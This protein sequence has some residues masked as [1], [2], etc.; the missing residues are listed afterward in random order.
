MKRNLLL[1]AGIFVYA[2][3]FAQGEIDAFR[4]SGTDLSGTARGQAM[5]GAFGA[6]GGDIT[7]ISINPA[8]I[9]VYRSSEVS[10][11]LSLNSTNIKTQWKN[12][13][14][15]KDHLKFNFDN[16]SYV[17]YYP[18]GK[19]SLQSV[20]FGFS[21]NKKKNFNRDYSASGT[22]MIT[23]LTDYIEN[24]TYGINRND[25]EDT[26]A[27]DKPGI[28]WLSVLGVDGNLIVKSKDGSEYLSFL[29]H[30]EKVSPR[31]KVSEKGYID[32]YDFNMGMNFSNSLYLGMTF[33]LT[34]VYYRMDSYYTEDF[35]QGGGFLLENYLQTEGSGFQFNLGTIWRPADFLRL[36]VAYHS[37]LWMSLSDFYKGTVDADLPSGDGGRVPL[38]FTPDASLDYRFRSPYSW[39]FSAAGILGTKAIVSADYEI[40]DYRS[41]NLADPHSSFSNS[42]E[43]QNEGIDTNF[44]VASILKAGLEYRFTSQFS[45]RL[46]YA[47]YEN[48]YEKSFRQNKKEV[49][50]A[51]T[52][53]HYTIEGDV[54]YFTAGIG[55]RF[56]PN[57]YLDV[58]FVYRTQ[59]DDLY[60]F[61]YVETDR[62]KAKDSSP[63]ASADPYYPVAA[64]FTN[65]AYKGLV[66]LGYKF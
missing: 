62:P 25:L 55:Y 5:G 4:L 29:D 9:G 51:G 1:I 33:S 39:V 10:T 61:P 50:T 65:T 14:N 44:K 12:T 2:C 37:P 41:M 36:G 20:N 60:F 22:G 56:S 7:G 57:F 43:G 40:K 32:S 64:S 30:E 34:D 8:G 66:T 48:P 46:G 59:K 18:V 38:A 47:R 42:F 24:I 31:L 21:Y 28:P 16:V 11:T 54:N 53:P 6:L 13:T 63:S 17:G 35:G 45:G 27:Y 15:N 19:S 49:I 3:S 26:H 52:I 23:S 58:A